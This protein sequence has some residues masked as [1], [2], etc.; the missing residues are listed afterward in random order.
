MTHYSPSRVVVVV[1]VSDSLLSF[2]PREKLSLFEERERDRERE[3]ETDRER[4][5]RERESLVLEYTIIE[6]QGCISVFNHGVHGYI[7]IHVYDD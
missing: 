5:P 4:V 2:H 1:V 7:E 3:R 6:N